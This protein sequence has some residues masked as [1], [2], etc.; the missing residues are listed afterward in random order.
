MFGQLSVSVG[1]PSGNSDSNGFPGTGT[2]TAA[3]NPGKAGDVEQ[4]TLDDRALVIACQEGDRDAFSTLVVR[5]QEAV[6]NLAYRRLGD[7]ELALDV[8][9]EVF[10]KA[11]KGLPKF[12]GESKFFTWIYRITLNEAVSAHRKTARHK[13][14]LSLDAQRTDGEGARLGEP[15]DDRAGP[16]DAAASLD[17]QALVQESIAD[18]DDEFAQPLILRDLEGLSYQEVSDVLQIP[19]GSVKSRI[20][21][22]RQTLKQRLAKVIE[23]A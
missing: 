7:R 17:D 10:I 14:A 12:E 5:Y 19:L 22:A 20:H 18:L 16:T 1:L 11:Y 15:A 21:R 6:L 9:Q 23:P 3:S 4:Q 13:R 8:A 2:Q